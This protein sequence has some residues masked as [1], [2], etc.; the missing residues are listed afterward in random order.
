[1][2]IADYDFPAGSGADNQYF[3]SE[4]HQMSHDIRNPLNSINGFAE[5]LLMDEGLSPATAD[6]VRAILSGS[7]ALTA[8]VT[9]YLDRTQERASVA[10]LAPGRMAS[11]EVQPMGRRSIF[12]QAR[13]A[14]S[15]RRFPRSERSGVL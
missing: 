5:L 15:S 14:A 7:Q 9:F 11:P 6:Y 13:R 1:M 3:A 8:A 12:K 2:G 4:F 10:P